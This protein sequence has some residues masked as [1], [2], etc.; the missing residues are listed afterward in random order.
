MSTFVSKSSKAEN[1]ASTATR[2]VDVI[3]LHPRANQVAIAH[4]HPSGNLRDSVEGRS[5]AVGEFHAGV[6]H[7][8]GGKRGVATELAEGVIE[9]ALQNHWLAVATGII[10]AYADILDDDSRRAVAAI[11]VVSVKPASQRPL[12]IQKQIA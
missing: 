3:H 6:R 10:R 11:I 12:W 4:H 7:E 1:R 5:R 2:R 8:G 9:S